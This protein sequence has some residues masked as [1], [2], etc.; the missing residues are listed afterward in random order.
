MYILTSNCRSHCSM[1]SIYV[2]SDPLQWHSSVPCDLM[3]RNARSFPVLVPGESV[4]TRTGTAQ[5]PAMYN[6]RC[7]LTG[8]SNSRRWWLG[9]HTVSRAISSQIWSFHWVIFLSITA[10][11][12][13]TVDFWNFAI[14]EISYPRYCKE[15]IVFPSVDS[16][17]WKKGWKPLF[18]QL[19]Y[20][21]PR[22]YKWSKLEPKLPLKLCV[23]EMGRLQPGNDTVT[24]YTGVVNLRTAWTSDVKELHIENLV[25]WYWD[26]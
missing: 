18:A 6:M 26:L 14:V 12:N 4:R 3:C 21:N 19:F 11:W 24:L 25:L 9:L 10:A 1:L 20:M 8:T 22:I 7:N 2:R 17:N 5:L 13:C 23:T 16:E 15:L